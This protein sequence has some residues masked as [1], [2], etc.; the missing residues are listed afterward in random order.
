MVPVHPAVFGIPGNDA[1]RK[2]IVAWAIRRIEHRNRIPSTPENLVRLGIVGAGRPHRRAASLPGIVLVLPG[3][4]ARLAWRGH[5][6]LSPHELA[7]RGIETG[8]PAPR[9]AITAGRADQHT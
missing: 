8:D 5:R 9:A 2:E 1:V 6:V 3:L 7:G 4:A